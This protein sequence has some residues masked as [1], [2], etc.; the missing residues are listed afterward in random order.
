MRGKGRSIAEHTEFTEAMINS[1]PKRPATSQA[2]VTSIDI[3]VG[4]KKSTHT[5]FTDS[6]SELFALLVCDSGCSCVGRAPAEEHSITSCSS[7]PPCMAVIAKKK[8]VSVATPFYA[9]GGV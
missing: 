1:G 7:L 2:M 5:R 8:K 4:W 6:V 9:V 3:T